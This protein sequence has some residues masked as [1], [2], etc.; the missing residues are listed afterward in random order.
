[1]IDGPT[2]P[3]PKSA[4]LTVEQEEEGRKVL[5][6]MRTEMH[7][8]IE[9][10]R[11][12]ALGDWC[13]RD[14]WT[15]KEACQLIAGLV[16][17]AETPEGVLR[18]R[19]Q[20]TQYETTI[21]CAETSLGAGNLKP[22]DGKDYGRAWPE[23]RVYPVQFLLWAKGKGF[24]IPKDLVGLLE[25]SKPAEQESRG[26]D[27]DPRE[28]TS[29]LQIIAV[30]AAEA[31]LPIEKHSKAAEILQQMGAQHGLDLPKKKDTIAG[32]LQEAR[33]LSKTR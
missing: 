29:L 10:L 2:D 28:R 19:M 6:E 1:M 3:P 16:P 25:A 31:K 4:R 9:V 24:D 8:G 14:L 23:R 18:K 20:G 15:V 22:F 12:K 30:L 32:K 21:A 7:S 17:D 5:E 13:L 33:D 11:R 27:L 26:A